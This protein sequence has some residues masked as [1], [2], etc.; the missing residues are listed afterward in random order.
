MSK[1]ERIIKLAPEKS[2]LIGTAESC[3][4]GMIASALTDI[5]GS[6][7][8]VDRGFVTYS[9]AAKSSMLGVDP[10]IIADHG[11]V[12]SPVVEAMAQGAVSALS[13]SQ[14]RIAVSV[15]GVAGPGG[16]SAE[17]PVGLVWFGL[18]HCHQDQINVLS[19]A[20]N[21][22]GDR[23]SVRMAA[24]DHALDMILNFLSEL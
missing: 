19:E 18:A 9:N 1:A 20:I 3:T 17:K 15:S 11:A 12:S 10:A 8:A 23:H 16:G 5:A 22:T 14:H 7:V 13:P 24:T 21:F 2:V 6:S 4:G